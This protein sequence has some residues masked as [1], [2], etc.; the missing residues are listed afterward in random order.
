VE[1]VLL[2]GNAKALPVARCPQ[3][4]CVMLIDLPGAGKTT[5]YWRHFAATHRLVSKD[6]WPNAPPPR[7]TPAADSEDALAH[8]ASPLILQR[9][10][11]RKQ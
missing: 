1:R 2:D 8:G 7:S 5:F 11:A 6:I 4:E 3:P 9:I 10:T